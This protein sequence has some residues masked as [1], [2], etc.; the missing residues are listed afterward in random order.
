MAGFFFFDRMLGILQRP[1]YEHYKRIEFEKCS[2]CCIDDTHLY[3]ESLYGDYMQL[4]P[5]EE[6][7]GRHNIHAYWL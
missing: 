7:V 5:I 2:F 6:R 4:P 1:I 3:L